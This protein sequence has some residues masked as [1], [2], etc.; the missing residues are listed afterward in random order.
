M[1]WLF[2][3]TPVIVYSSGL[4]DIGVNCWYGR[5][6]VFVLRLQSCGCVVVRM[7]VM[8]LLVRLCACMVVCWC[9]SL[10]SAC[11]SVNVLFG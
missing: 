8:L 6:C 4:G 11:A 1:G 10:V 2:S 7:I 3:G 9:D 5:V